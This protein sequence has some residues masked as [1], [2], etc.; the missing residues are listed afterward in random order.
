M[1]HA[2][3]ILED[4]NRFRAGH[5]FSRAGFSIS[6][7]RRSRMAR[8]KDAEGR[9]LAGRTL[10]ADMTAA[11]PNDS[12]TGRQSEAVAVRFLGREER[13]EQPRFDLVAHSL[14]FVGHL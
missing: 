2:D 13:L 14:A 9:A 3:F 11:L 10:G 6:R 1:P 5:V 8:K 12:V 4:E 7:G